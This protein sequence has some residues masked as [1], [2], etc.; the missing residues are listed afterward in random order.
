MKG[1]T[2]IVLGALVLIFLLSAG[3]SALEDYARPVVQILKSGHDVVRFERIAYHFRTTVGVTVIFEKIDDR[4]VELVVKPIDF[5]LPIIDISLWWDDFP[6]NSLG[7]VA[8]GD[9]SWTL[10]TETGYAEK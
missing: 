3:V 9:N 10:D 1:S 8:G 7:L 6:V 5:V 2:K 4:Y